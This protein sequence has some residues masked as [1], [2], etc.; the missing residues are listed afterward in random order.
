[1]AEDAEPKS[2]LKIEAVNI[3]GEP[4]PGLSKEAIRAQLIYSI[5]GLIV[6][7][8]CIPSG[9]L[10]F[11]AGIT[12]RMTWTVSI[13]GSRW[14]VLD[15]TPGALLIVAGVMIVFLTRFVVKIKN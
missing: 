5:A 13:L 7:L 4:P 1:M 11:W 15:A 9:L 8:M 3:T 12:G 2:E 14:K 6:A 10:L